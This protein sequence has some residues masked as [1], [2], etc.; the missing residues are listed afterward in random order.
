MNN[1]SEVLFGSSAMS[2]SPATSV[3]RAVFPNVWSDYS[4][5]ELP[6]DLLTALQWSEKLWCGNGL[7]RKALE[8]VNRFFITKIDISEVSDSERDRYRAVLEDYLKVYDSLIQLLDDLM[9]YGNSF[10]SLYVPFR[11]FL[12]CNECGF[13]QPL[14]Q[15]KS[16]Q[17]DDFKFRIRCASCHKQVTAKVK[18]WRV[19]DLSRL[20]IIRWDPK[21]MH[22]QH[23]DWTQQTEFYLTIPDNIAAAVKKGDQFILSTVP[24]EVIETI[25]R[26]S[27]F[28]FDR[29]RIFHMKEPVLAGIRTAGWGMPRYISVFRQVFHVQVLKRFNEALAMDY[30]MPVRVVCPSGA[31]QAD[32]SVMP[33]PVVQSQVASIFATHRRDPS[34]ISFSPIPLQYMSMSGEGREMATYEMINAATSELLDA[35]GVPQD[36]QRGTL[37]VQA[38]PMA[39][40]MMEQSNVQIPSA[41]HDW[42]TWLTMELAR[43]Y[44]YEVPTVRMQKPSLADDME[45]KQMLM[46]LAAAKEVSKTTAY[47]P[48]NLDIKNEIRRIFQ[49]QADQADAE[50]EFQREEEERMKT[51]EQFASFSQQ[52]SQQPPMPPGGMPPMPPGPGGMVTAGPPGTPTPGG[53][54]RP[55]SVQEINR[56]AEEMAR[57]L[58][59]MPA[60]ARRSQLV[61]LKQHDPDTHALVTQKLRDLR[62][63]AS[64]MGQQMVIQQGG[65]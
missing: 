60:E 26:G 31:P 24:W 27:L 30:I 33:M 25:K 21:F 49:E 8:R 11:R 55:Q 48:L 58:L 36:L 19:H 2:A 40:R 17:W 43:T 7:Y 1:P 62:Q 4:N 42:L 50:R 14:D 6:R 39:I 65:P 59:T 32:P 46:Q 22:L 47:G 12:I 10:S 61:S 52:A 5:S 44:N 9:A 38:M 57:Q 56:R 29:Q 18:D 13:S 34:S 41:I 16:F 45:Y 53:L 15:I 20:G 23:N 28:H 35:I 54:Q 51:E 63:Q 37:Q 64:S 3:S